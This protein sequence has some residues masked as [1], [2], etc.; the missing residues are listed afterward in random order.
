VIE[1]DESFSD[2]ADIEELAEELPSNSPRYVIL[3][4][5]LVS[6]P[7]ALM[8]ASTRLQAAGEHQADWTD[9]EMT[10]TEARRKLG[11]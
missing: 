6:R 1:E 11:R 7:L 3:S 2:L 4:Y 9:R 10:Q 5:Q 8:T